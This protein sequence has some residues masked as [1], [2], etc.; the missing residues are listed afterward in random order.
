MISLCSSSADGFF[1]M[2]SNLAAG[3]GGEILTNLGIFEAFVDA[4]LVLAVG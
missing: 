2:L 3:L 4:P 1:V